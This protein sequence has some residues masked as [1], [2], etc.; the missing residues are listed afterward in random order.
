VTV[1]GVGPHTTA[2]PS[3]GP[4][5]DSTPHLPED[6]R[7]LEREEG[8]EQ[9]ADTRFRTLT[10]T[11]RT[12]FPDGRIGWWYEAESIPGKARVDV[13]PF[14][15][16][17]AQ[18]FRNDSAYVFQNA[19]L[20]RR[21]AGLAATMWTLMDMYSVPP[22][23]TA[24]ALGRRG[25]DLTR[26]YEREHNSTPVIVIGALAGDTTSAQFWLDKENLYTVR[27]TTSRGGHRVTE[28]GKHVFMGGGWVE[29]EI[30]VYGPNHQLNL[31]EEYFD[32]RVNVELPATLFDGDVYRTPPWTE[33]R[34]ASLRR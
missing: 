6:R 27:M 16:R 9:G 22:E 7:E 32:V 5:S 26:V 28:V 1:A 31:L 19:E 20:A 13:A 15:N 3:R 23:E 17:N 21:S 29:Q 18:I 33:T 12:T 30:K 10:F 34:P 11:Q 25:F 24:A 2:A 8:V 4:I 14:S